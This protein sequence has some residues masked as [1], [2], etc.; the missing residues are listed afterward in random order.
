MK[1]FEYNG[2]V[3]AVNDEANHVC[4]W[5]GEFFA[6]WFCESTRPADWHVLFEV[7]PTDFEVTRSRFSRSADRIRCFTL[8]GHFASHP[9]V[10]DTENC[11]LILDQQYEVIYRVD[12]A[13]RRVRVLD[14]EARGASRS[15]VMRV[16]RELATTHCLAE[17]QLHLHGSAVSLEEKALIAVGPK[18]AGKTTFLLRMLREAQAEFI[19]NDRLFLD[20]ARREVRGM[21]TVIRLRSA[22]LNSMPWLMKPFRSRP[23][24]WRETVGEYRPHTGRRDRRIAK[25][26]TNGVSLTPAQFCKLT[27]ARLIRQATLGAIIFPEPLGNGKM[28][29]QALS[30]RQSLARLHASVLRGSSPQAHAEAFRTES[31]APPACEEKVLQQCADMVASM[32]C[33]SC[34]LGVSLGSA[35]RQIAA[36]LRDAA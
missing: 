5:L 26:E 16:V 7:N 32:P 18:R 3:V 34:R 35:G 20:T 36:I 14:R 29:F 19:S 17:G 22:T 4:T 12:T 21:P 13:H 11:R 23:Y 31:L 27:D 28:R 25:A 9:M 8:D 1:H 30:T 24:S 10:L 6:P 33:F 15:A 2:H